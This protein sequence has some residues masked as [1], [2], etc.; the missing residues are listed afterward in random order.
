[1]EALRRRQKWMG[2][3]DRTEMWVRPQLISFFPIIFIAIWQAR[4]A[5][6]DAS[7]G[8]SKGK[9]WPQ[10][11]WGTLRCSNTF[12]GW[13]GLFLHSLY[14]CQW[15]PHL[16]NRSKIQ[17]TSHPTPG[18]STT[19][20]VTIQASAVPLS[21]KDDSYNQ[22]VAAHQGVKVYSFCSHS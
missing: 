6:L 14:T 2:R 18:C 8:L 5:L 21:H 16:N 10:A 3:F 9:A 15:P 19:K 4:I 12:F 13:R 22:V 20:L 11:S 7:A 1:M 17:P